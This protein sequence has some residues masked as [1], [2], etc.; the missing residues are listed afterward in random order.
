MG[1]ESHPIHESQRLRE[2]DTSVSSILFLNIPY[3][4]LVTS[5]TG[6]VSGCPQRSG[7]A[8]MDH[9]GGVGHA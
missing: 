6:S 5:K 2:Y 4:L 1:K 7:V 9:G 3:V 8:A